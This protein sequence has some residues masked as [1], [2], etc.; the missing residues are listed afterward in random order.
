MLESNTGSAGGVNVT[1]DIGSGCLAQAAA[2][3]TVAIKAYF[4]RCI[5]NNPIICDA[6]SS[7]RDKPKAQTVNATI[8][9]HDRCGSGLVEPARDRFI[10]PCHAKS[11][12]RAALGRLYAATQNAGPKAGVCYNVAYSAAIG[13]RL[14]R[15]RSSISPRKLRIRPW[16]GQAA[17]SPR[18]QIV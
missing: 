5:L 10:T 1:G 14:W 7:G 13:P 12:P 3:K 18:A 9:D 8:A 11:T 16:I 15:M 2:S 6:T 4:I 17:A